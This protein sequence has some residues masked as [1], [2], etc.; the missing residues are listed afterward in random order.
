MER[1]SRQLLVIELTY[2][3]ELKAQPRRSEL[4]QT[5]ELAR[6]ARIN[7]TRGING[8]TKLTHGIKDIPELSRTRVREL[9]S[10][11]AEKNKGIVILFTIPVIPIY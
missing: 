10:R 6:P 8:T 3:Y 11:L 7:G 4:S 2:G 1:L 5:V 9:R